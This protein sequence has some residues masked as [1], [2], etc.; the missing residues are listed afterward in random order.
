MNQ[1]YDKYLYT[2][3]SVNGVV[4]KNLQVYG[5]TRPE[6]DDKIAQ[7]YRRCEILSCERLLPAKAVSSNFEDVLDAIV[8]S[9][10]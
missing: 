10:S 8:H 2:I 6:A 1:A 4:V 7:M 9:D 3:R 5:K